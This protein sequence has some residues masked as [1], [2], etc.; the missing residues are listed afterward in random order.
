MSLFDFF[1]SDKSRPSEQK[2]PTETKSTLHDHFKQ[3]SKQYQSGVP[4]LKGGGEPQQA[5]EDL[6]KKINDL[7]NDLGFVTLILKGVLHK[8]DEKGV[9]K[10]DEIKVLLY[11]AMEGRSEGRLNINFLK[12]KSS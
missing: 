4:S 11:D 10:K 9:I 5:G 8:L 1:F 3:Y 6:E 2:P 7:E 12:E